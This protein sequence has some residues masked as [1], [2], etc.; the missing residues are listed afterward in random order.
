ME[1][2]AILGKVLQDQAFCGIASGFASRRISVKR[3]AAQD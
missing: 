2:E 1:A 3:P